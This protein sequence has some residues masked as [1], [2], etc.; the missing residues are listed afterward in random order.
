MKKTLLI[1]GLVLVILAGGVYVQ[2]RRILM[3]VGSFLVSRDPLIHADGIAVLSGQVPSRILEGI[4]LY[5]RGFSPRI[6]LTSYEGN[7]EYVRLMKSLGIT[8]QTDFRVQR[9]IALNQGV[10]AE[11]IEV[12]PPAR[13]TRQEAKVIFDYMRKKG[14]RSVIVVTSE[15]HSTRTRL[16]FRSLNRHGVKVAVHPSRYERMRLNS[17]WRDRGQSKQ[18]FYEYVKLINHYTAGF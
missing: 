1:L 17:W 4:D 9:W 14:W 11:A 6:F 3:A 5:R 2:R 10:P 8:Y 16:I 15:Y 13:S 12:L 7:P 18:I